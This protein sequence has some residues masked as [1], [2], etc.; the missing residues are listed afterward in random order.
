[1]KKKLIAGAVM[2]SVLVSFAAP[3]LAQSLGSGNL[4]VP[5][6]ISSYR[7]LFNGTGMILQVTRRTGGDVYTLRLRQAIPLRKIEIQARAGA[8]QVHETNLIL[9]SGE[10]IRLYEVSDTQTFSAGQMAVSEDILTERNVTAIE[11]TAE[12]MGSNADVAIVAY[13]AIATPQLTS[14]DNRPPIYQIPG[15]NTNTNPA[16]AVYGDI[17]GQLSQYDQ[18]LQTW[19]QR[20]QAAPSGSAEES[21]AANQMNIS[22]QKMVQ[23][24][25]SAQASAL[26]LSVLESLGQSYLNKYQAAAS[27]SVAEKAYLQVAQAVFADMSA[28]LD[29]KIRCENMGSQALLNVGASYAAKYQAAPSGSISESTFNQLSQQAYGLVVQRYQQESYYKNYQVLESE[30]IDFSNKYQA[31]P[32]GSISERTYLQLSQVAFAASE[33]V[34]GATIGG[35][36]ADQKFYLMKDYQNKYNAAPSGSALETHYRNMQAILNRG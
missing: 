21:F 9:D 27:G 7:N 15:S 29:R 1:M 3:C 8:L 19:G 25:Q 26:D 17:R 4:P 14:I 33:R 12:S 28:A 24:A 11:V 23:L 13:S 34:F 20:Y 6:D 5:G 32:S 18:D 30:G 16:C 22:A 10:R 35:L 31:A 2:A 36:T